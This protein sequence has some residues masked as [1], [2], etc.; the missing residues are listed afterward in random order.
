MNPFVQDRVK[1]EIL[2]EEWRKAQIPPAR[3]SV[4]SFI[5][6]LRI[7]GLWDDDNV[8]RFVEDKELG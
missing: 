3:N 2:F 6:F 4:Q 8:H 1:L 5:V 7:N